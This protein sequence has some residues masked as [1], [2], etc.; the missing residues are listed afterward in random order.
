MGSVK[1]FKLQSFCNLSFFTK[2]FVPLVFSVFLPLAIVHIYLYPLFKFQFQLG[3][4]VNVGSGSPS[5]SPRPSRG[6]KSLFLFCFSLCFFFLGLTLK[7]E[8]CLCCFFF[9]GV[10]ILEFLRLEFLVIMEMGNG[11]GPR[12]DLYTMVLLAAPLKI[13]RT[14]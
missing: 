11:F 1:S 14:A 4:S 12:L 2:K 8:V 10:Q 3:S 13:T 9:L 7:K 6:K 5:P